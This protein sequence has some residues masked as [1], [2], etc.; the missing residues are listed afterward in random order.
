M[1]KQLVWIAA[2]A[3]VGLMNG[4]VR[5]NQCTAEDAFCVDTN[6]GSAGS[7]NPLVDATSRLPWQG[8]VA[9]S[10]GNDPTADSYLFLD[11]DANGPDPL[12]GYLGLHASDPLAFSPTGDF[13]RGGG[14]ALSPPL[15]TGELI[16]DAPALPFE[17]PAAPTD[18]LPEP[19]VAIPGG[20]LP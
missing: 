6:N 14:N 9:A 18:L 10:P 5:A 15:P 7:G 11:G 2:L 8:I 3:W 20:V 16:P 12:D 1:K 19:P 4:P 17:L 13:K